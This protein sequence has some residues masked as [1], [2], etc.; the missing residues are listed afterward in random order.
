MQVFR[1]LKSRYLHMN[2]KNSKPSITLGLII[3]I[4]VIA[5]LLITILQLL[6]N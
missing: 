5:K 4:L 2:N 3:K 1:A 6:L